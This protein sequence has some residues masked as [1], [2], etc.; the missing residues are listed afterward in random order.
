MVWKIFPPKLSP[1]WVY[2][3]DG[4]WLRRNGVILIHRNATD[5]EVL[6]WS[7]WKSESYL[8]LETDLTLLTSLLSEDQYPV[9][10]VSD[11]K[12]CIRAAVATHLGDIPHQRCISHVTRDV[13][14]LLPKHSPIEATQL[15][16]HI[17]LDII[18]V[19]TIADKQAWITWLN[20]WLTFYGDVL[21]EKS[22]REEGILTK[23]RW[24]YTHKNIRAAYRLLTTNQDHLFVYLDHSKIPTTNNGLEGLNSNLKTKL[25]N[26]RGMKHPQQYAFVSW[27]LTLQKVKSV[28]DLKKLWAVW[29]KLS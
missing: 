13:R 1:S 5:H 14:R 8:A 16:R 24:W 25:A 7:W 17:G 15:L 4:K 20:C 22:Y 6:W 29:R 23:R 11:W 28:V 2:S 27:Y 9:G 10:A 18:R 21:S 12:G 19:K 26:H 3:I